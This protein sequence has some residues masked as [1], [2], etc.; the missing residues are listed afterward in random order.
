MTK[1]DYYREAAVLITG[2]ASGIGR[3]LARLAAAYGARVLASD[4]NTAGLAHTAQLCAQAGRPIETAPLDVTDAAAIS[5]YAEAVLPTLQ[6]QR[7]I[8]I[9]NAG[10]ALMSGRFAD[11]TVAEM[12]WLFEVNYW[13]PVRLCQAFLPYLLDQNAGHIVNLSSVFGLGGFLRQSAYSPTKFALRG[14]TEVLRMELLGTQVRTT[15]VHPGGIDTGIVRHARVSPHMRAAQGR[16]IADFARNAQT[17]PTR[18]A[19]VILAALPRNQQRVLIGWD[20]HLI[21][22]LIRL[23]PVRYTRLFGQ[24]AQQRFADPYQVGATAET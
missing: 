21:D 8:L 10:S 17:K 13:G 24:Q 18:A 6:G 1:T 19:Q 23:L 4:H 22:W 15:V 5:A 20:A 3:E 11:T 14:F 2:A 16:V 7:L 9:N 12:Q